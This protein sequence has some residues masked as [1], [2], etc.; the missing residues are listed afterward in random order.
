V[1][2]VLAAHGIL[3]TVLPYPMR[4]AHL[5]ALVRIAQTHREAHGEAGDPLRR[6]AAVFALDASGAAWMAERLRLS[7]HQSQRLARLAEAVAASPLPPPGPALRAALYREGAEVLRDRLLLQAAAAE[8]ENAPIPSQRVAATLDAIAAWT[9]K[10]LP[11]G[12]A[13][14]QARGVPPGPRIGEA[15]RAVESWWI[16]QDFAPDRDAC[17][18]RLDS[19]LDPTTSV[20]QPESSPGRHDTSPSTG[21]G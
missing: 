20:T 2:E 14:V 6:L 4:P 15:L 16:D 10:R 13:D 3:E 8:V 11:V 21:S 12:G 5:A 7:R 9:P 18:A 17:L 19:V 1:A